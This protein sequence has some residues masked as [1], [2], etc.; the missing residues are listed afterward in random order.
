MTRSLERRKIIT[1][2]KG[3]YNYN[4]VIFGRVLRQIQVELKLPRIVFTDVFGVDPQ[5]KID[6]VNR[7]L[8][9]LVNLKNAI[10]PNIDKSDIK[11]FEEHWDNFLNYVVNEA[12]GEIIFVPN[13]EIIS[14][15]NN[16]NSIKMIEVFIGDAQITGDISIVI[17]PLFRVREAIKLK[18]E[19]M[20]IS[21]KIDQTQLS[22]FDDVLI[23]D[24]VN[25]LAT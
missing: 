14:L 22:H 12:V 15:N 21:S 3:R 7:P 1:P 24:N 17:I 11:K 9:F 20:D 23:D 5:N 8:I 6:F 19:E 13:K 16:S 18:A 4:Q 25:I 2:N 10:F